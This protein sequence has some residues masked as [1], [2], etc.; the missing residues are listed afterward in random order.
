MPEWTNIQI[1]ITF[2]DL[3]WRIN[4]KFHIN[5][6]NT[7]RGL[8]LFGRL[9]GILATITE[10]FFGMRSSSLYSV[11]S[12]IYQHHIKTTL[13]WL[14]PLKHQQL[15]EGPTLCKLQYAWCYNPEFVNEFM[16]ADHLYSLLSPYKPIA[17]IEKTA[18]MITNL[19][20][21]R[22]L[23]DHGCIPIGWRDHWRHLATLRNDHG[24]HDHC[25]LYTNDINDQGS[26]TGVHT[27]KKP[28]GFFWVYPPTHSG[29]NLGSHL[30]MY[31]TIGLTDH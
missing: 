8:P 20:L 10:V 18:A 19:W 7:H 3:I 26:E 12:Y 11:H 24:D 13:L 27:Q 15:W 23:T 31:W 9:I 21:S 16:I 17:V 14:M 1:F 5:I 6:T 22:R 4:E 25:W 28:T 30:T 2:Q 29:V